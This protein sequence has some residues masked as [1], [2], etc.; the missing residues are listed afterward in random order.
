MFSPTSDCVRDPWGLCEATNNVL[1]SV[2][3]SATPCRHGEMWTP[4]V[5]AQQTAKL[6]R[7]VWRRSAC[8]RP[9]ALLGTVPKVV[10]RTRRQARR[11]ACR[12]QPRRPVVRTHSSG[13]AREEEEVAQKLNAGTRRAGQV[14][15]RGQAQGHASQRLRGHVFLN[16]SATSAGSRARCEEA[17]HSLVGHKKIVSGKPPKL[18]SHRR[19]RE[20]APLQYQRRMLEADGQKVDKLRTLRV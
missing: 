13:R 16:E 18:C 5:T 7:E 3:K 12:E 4:H 1:Q 15:L 14:V 2:Q 20:A 6:G 8:W 19:L 17:Q 11:V 9:G 10:I